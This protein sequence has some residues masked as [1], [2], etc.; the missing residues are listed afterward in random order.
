MGIYNRN[1]GTTD[2]PANHWLD[3]YAHGER[4]REPGCG[5]NAAASR[6]LLKQRRRELRDG[7]WVH[8]DKR[9]DDSLTVSAWGD[10]YWAQR[11]AD[12]SLRPGRSLQNVHDQQTRYL[13]YVAPKIGSRP[14]RGV[15]RAD[16]K[17]IVADLV[18][19]R[20]DSGD[21]K[22]A[23]RTIIHVYDAVR[24]MFAAA[25]AH[26]PPLIER[27]PCTLEVRLGELPKK[28]DK[29]PAWRSQATFTHGELH[30]L[31]TDERNP[32][33]RRML[34]AL[35]FF[36][37]VRFGEG[38]GRR[39]LDYDQHARPL[40][41]IVC[42]TQYDGLPLK[43]DAPPRD[44]PVHPYLAWMLAEWLSWGFELVMGRP[45]KAE[46]W[47]VPSRLGRVRSLKHT[48]RRLEEDLERIGLRRRTPHN[49]RAA[50]ISLAQQ[51]GG[52]RHVLEVITHKGNQDVWG[53]YT[54]HQWSALCDH[55]S[56]LKL[57]PPSGPQ[58]QTRSHSGVGLS[59]LAGTARVL[60]RDGRDLNPG[61]P[62]GMPRNAEE[63]QQKALRE[64]AES[65][66]DL[67]AEDEP[68]TERVS[69]DLAAD[70]RE[71]AD[72]AR[73]GRVDHLTGS[74]RQRLA[75]AAEAAAGAFDVPASPMTRPGVRSAS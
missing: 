27:T 35:I 30:Q 26:D 60:Q 7:T 40:G 53:G 1:K 61:T 45:P 32:F 58:S 17:D 25:L 56:R 9:I 46:D 16:I 75:S 34:Y 42:A 73:S 28:R 67:D 38:A 64:Y 43:G 20:T 47:I 70:L 15:K 55:V 12:A 4:I 22:L 8:P 74:D 52:E 41:R 39:F 72:V 18:R 54:R 29:N 50:F 63:R 62:Q 68:V 49:L 37:A 66:G 69:V 36:G 6:E 24:G 71:L 3:Y 57:Y 23:P 13:T 33:D 65:R 2:R 11:R 48:E 14:L 21:P 59:Q 19:L 10:K 5:A 31:F 44:I 51:D